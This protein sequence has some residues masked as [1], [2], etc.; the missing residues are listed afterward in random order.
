LFFQACDENGCELFQTD[1]TEIT[2]YDLNPL[3]DSRPNGF[4]VFQGEMYFSA[5]GPNGRQVF[6]ASPV[7][8]PNAGW[9]GLL[10]CVG[11]VRR[12]RRGC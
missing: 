5:F 6:K 11:L 1:G 7:P 4:T 8:E 12:R 3:G 2:Q 10:A 9:L